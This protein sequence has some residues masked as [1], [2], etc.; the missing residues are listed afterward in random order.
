M[1]LSMETYTLR[2]LYGD[3][4]AFAMLKQAG[5][6]GVDYSFY[7]YNDPWYMQD[8]YRAHAARL[9]GWLQEVG[10]TCVQAHAPFDLLY[11]ES[12]NEDEPHYHMVVRALEC[13]A[14]LGARCIV[15][16]AL[17][18]PLN[19]PDEQTMQ[20][21]YEY[22]KTLQPYCEK[23]GIQ[24]AVE[25]LFQYDQ[26]RKCTKSLL[27]SPKALC[28]MLHRLDSPWFTACV[29]V[30]HGAVNGFEPEDFLLAMEPELLGAVHIQDTDFLDDRH[31][32]PF[33]QDH[34][35]KAIMAALKQKN[36][37]GDMN[38]EIFCY[39]ERLPEPLLADGLAFAAKIG[40]Y[41]MS[42]LGE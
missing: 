19:M 42:L 8:D 12:W 1:K 33:T 6:D 4:K 5:F 29:D 39:V 25:N 15:V 11:G 22:Y 35:W 2:N 16:H 32:L 41:L 30:G 3:Q 23:F 27:G 38:L 26:K 9:R 40:R 37:R 36:F 18:T 10:L 20:I 21:N 14:I 24:I 13:A 28:D 34:D 31:M 17:E 7:L